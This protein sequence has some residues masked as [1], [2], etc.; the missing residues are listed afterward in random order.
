MA[1][2]T[3]GETLAR[4]IRPQTRSITLTD[5]DL[6]AAALTQNIALGV[7]LPDLAF[8]TAHSLFLTTEFASP[9]AGSLD[10]QVGDDTNDD[11]SI[12]AAYD[13]YTGS[14]NLGLWTNGDTIGINPTGDPSGSQ[15]QL[16]LTATTDNL[17]TF[18]AGSCT[19]KVY[20]QVAVNPE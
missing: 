4:L 18:T 20:F 19:I 2:Q 11:D 14:A 10:I 1:E 8:I 5:A 3:W 6:T 16:A 9:G 17:N 12:V 15:L 13:A 7:A